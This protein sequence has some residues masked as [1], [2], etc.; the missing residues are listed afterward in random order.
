MFPEHNQ[1]QL[2]TTARIAG[3]WYLLMAISG[4]LGFMIFHPQVYVSADPQKTLANL[5][6]NESLART[7]L[8]L[9]F[10]IIVS[11]AL[12]AV[13]FFKLFRKINDWAAWAVGIWGMVN[14]VVI[15]ISA[16]S[17]GTAIDIAGSSQ[18]VEDKLILIELLTDLSSNAWRVGG[19]FFGLWLIPLG[20]IITSSKRMPLWL[21]RTLI[22]GG[23]GYL[24]STTISYSGIEFPPAKYLTI[25]ATIGE[26]WMIG[27]LLIFGIRPLKESPSN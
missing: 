7:R 13:W 1:R 27:Y 17:M 26:F 14:S 15:I 21:G 6:D 3:I 4:I 18:N 19:L 10:G 12:T 16:I 24:L 23:I 11:Q 8:L 25:P 22:I 20:Y 9:E 2:V 5:I